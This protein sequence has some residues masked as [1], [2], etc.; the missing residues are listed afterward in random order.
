MGY[1]RWVAIFTSQKDAI[2]DFGQTAP[3]KK[4][5]NRMTVLDLHTRELYLTDPVLGEPEVPPAYDPADD[6][7]RVEPIPNGGPLSTEHLLTHL[8]KHPDCK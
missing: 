6:E 1:E 4:L 3:E 8:P 7:V 5:W 2:E